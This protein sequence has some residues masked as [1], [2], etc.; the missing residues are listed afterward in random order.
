EV[1]DEYGSRQEGEGLKGEIARARVLVQA[2]KDIAQEVKGRAEGL[3]QVAR[4]RGE[5]DTPPTPK[6]IAFSEGGLLPGETPCPDAARR[7]HVLAEDTWDLF[8][9]LLR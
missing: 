2:G 4:Y 3:K 5:K 6:A 9:V 8:R 7:G 1:A